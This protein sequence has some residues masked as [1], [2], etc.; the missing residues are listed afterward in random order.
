MQ[1]INPNDLSALSKRL[2]LG[3]L[4][5]ASSPPTAYRK[6]LQVATPTPPLRLAMGQQWVHLFVCGSKHSTDLRLELP[7]RPPTAYSL[8]TWSIVKKTF[9]SFFRHAEI[10]WRLHR[11]E[12]IFSY[13]FD[14]RSKTEVERELFFFLPYRFQFVPKSQQQLNC[15]SLFSLSNKTLL[16]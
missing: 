13:S 9:F 7:S 11:W 14:V 16:S 8:W 12:M 1:K 5:G 6:P 15:L 10:D 4:A 3:L 2:Q